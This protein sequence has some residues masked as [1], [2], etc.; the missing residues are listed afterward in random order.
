MEYM[1]KSLKQTYMLAAKHI[2]KLGSP[3]IAASQRGL[4]KTASL[5]ARRR[6]RKASKQRL[7][8]ST[9]HTLHLWLYS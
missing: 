8:E 4:E 3:P 7:G 9:Y 6:D 2:A 1:K 5:S